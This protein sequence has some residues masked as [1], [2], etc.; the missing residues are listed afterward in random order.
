MAAMDDPQ[1]A[2]V[3]HKIVGVGWQ[4]LIFEEWMPVNP[5]VPQ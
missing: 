2:A 1:L 4:R 5:K 3:A